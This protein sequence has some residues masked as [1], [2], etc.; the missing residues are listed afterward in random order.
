[1]ELLNACKDGRKDEV[2]NLINSGIDVNVK[3]EVSP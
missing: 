3:D 2:F 1:M